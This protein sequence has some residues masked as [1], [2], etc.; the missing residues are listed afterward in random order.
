MSRPAA[1]FCAVLA[2]AALA[3]GGCSRSADP[4][5][6]ESLPEPEASSAPTGRAP[7]TV[8]VMSFNVGGFSAD[9]PEGVADTLAAAV[10]DADP[11]ILILQGMGPGDALDVFHAALVRAGLQPYPRLAVLA[12]DRSPSNLAFLSRIPVSS[13]TPILEDYYSIGPDR[14]AVQHGFLDLRFEP[15]G[16]TPPFRILAADLKDKVFHASGQTEMRRNEAR[17]LANHVRAAFRAD[18]DARLLV[19][20]SFN[21]TPDSAAVRVILDPALGLADLRPLDSFGRSWT[22]VSSNDSCERSDYL[23]ASPSLLPSTHAVLLDHPA[24]PSATPHR[25]LLLTLIL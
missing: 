9:S 1:A 7:G 17:L 18:P 8:R 24:L 6:G 23:L 19:C 15:E 16:I 4:A 2:A 13:D 10:A 20:G 14:F 3:L 22:S 5:Q 21:D 11:D 25:P 12:A